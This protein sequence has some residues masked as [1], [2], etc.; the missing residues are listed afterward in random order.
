[1]MVLVVGPAKDRTLDFAYLKFCVAYFAVEHLLLRNSSQQQYTVA[2][3]CK[4]VAGDF[5]T[6][7]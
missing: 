4:N 7:R 2:L 5:R 3:A 6:I 1:M